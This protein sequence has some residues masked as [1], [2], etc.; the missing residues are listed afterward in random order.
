MRNAITL[1]CTVMMAMGCAGSP[2]SMEPPEIFVSTLRLLPEAD[3]N[4]PDGRDVSAA[5]SE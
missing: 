1:I 5:Q 4:P 3:G 2:R